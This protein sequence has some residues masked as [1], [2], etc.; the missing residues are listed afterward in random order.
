[1]YPGYVDNT[2]KES[3]VAPNLPG[4]ANRISRG[5]LICPCGNVCVPSGLQGRDL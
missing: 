3:M 4:N 5:K 1:M 2:S